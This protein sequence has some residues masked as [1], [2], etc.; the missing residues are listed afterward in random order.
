MEVTFAI[1]LFQ[2]R[3]CPVTTLKMF[4]LHDLLTG[5]NIS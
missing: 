2:V 4:L 5:L 1:Y 3:W